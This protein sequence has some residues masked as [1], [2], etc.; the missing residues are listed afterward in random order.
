[1][2]GP[3]RLAIVLGKGGTGRTAVTVAWARRCALWGPTVALELDESDDLARRVGLSGRS[4]APRRSGTIDVMS[5]SAPDAL[6]DFSRRKLGGLLGRAVT[7][8]WTRAFLDSLPGLSDAVQLGKIENLLRE[9]L[10]GDPHWD[11]AVLDAPATGHGTSLLDAPRTLARLGRSGPFAQL[12]GRIADL[13]DD[14]SQTAHILV[15]RPEALPVSESRA[16][17]D[18]L[19]ERGLAIDHWVVVCGTPDPLPGPPSWPEGRAAL[20]A[21]GW[22]DDPGGAEAIGL[23]D[24]IEARREAEELRLAELA[25][26]L[27]AATAWSLRPD[28][29]LVPR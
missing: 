18:Q 2:T 7:S 19:A 8:R 29:S 15:T 11:F 21:G 25:R 27:P 23:I 13:I 3:Q 24:R 10:P 17:A 28:G 22:S 9:P 4:Y 14:P 6:D 20:V 5:L 16:L 26:S 1:M 12:A